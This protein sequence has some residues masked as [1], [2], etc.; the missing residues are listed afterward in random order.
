MLLVVVSVVEETIQF[1]FERTTWPCSVSGI[2]VYV[3]REL[4]I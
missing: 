3:I 4:L 2:G 1:Q